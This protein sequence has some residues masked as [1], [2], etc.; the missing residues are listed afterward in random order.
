MIDG[1][2]GRDGSIGVAMVKGE[3]DDGVG[4][5]GVTLAPVAALKPVADGHGLAL[6]GRRVSPKSI[7]VAVHDHRVQCD[8]SD[9]RSFECFGGEIAVA[10]VALILGQEAGQEF[11]FNPGA[12]PGLVVDATMTWRSV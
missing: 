1:H 3:P 7:G 6:I 4:C 8:P 5:F 2:R 10:V 11:G 12:I 9:E